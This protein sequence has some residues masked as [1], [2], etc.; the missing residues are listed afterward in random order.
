[1]SVSQKL[2]VE[3]HLTKEKEGEDDKRHD[4]EDAYG[5]IEPSMAG[6]QRVVLVAA[7]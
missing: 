5:R 2:K 1:M 4:S 7:E 3:E 6:L